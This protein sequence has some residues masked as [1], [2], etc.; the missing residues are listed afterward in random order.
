ML[1]VFFTACILF[2]AHMLF[3]APPQ[4]SANQDR[5]DKLIEKKSFNESELSEL[6]AV[7]ALEKESGSKTDCT[8]CPDAFTWFLATH[9]FFDEV[10][11]LLDHNADYGIKD[12]DGRTLL[13]VVC[14]GEIRNLQNSSS[15][16]APRSI[17]R[18]WKDAPPSIT[19][20]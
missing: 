5:F 16:A 7:M 18:T 13:H 11:W 10:S 19:P 3:A 14:Q 1:K 6:H 20:P 4:T 12:Q 9:N 15:N 17:C 8:F 2:A